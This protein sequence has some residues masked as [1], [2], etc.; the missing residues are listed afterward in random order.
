ML[1]RSSYTSNSRPTSRSTSNTSYSSFSSRSN[2]RN[3]NY[4]KK[5]NNN[6]K[7]AKY[8]EILPGINCS[9]DYS[10]SQ[11]KQCMKCVTKNLHHEYQCPYYF[12]YSQNKCSKCKKGFHLEYECN[13]QF[14]SRSNSQSKIS[15][16]SK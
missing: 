10:K 4:R 5:S 2:S 13:P 11:M 15:L 12:K 9:P 16:N 3:R 8:Q 1:F 7:P 14:R 6:K